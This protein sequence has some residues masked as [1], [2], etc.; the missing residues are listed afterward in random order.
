MCGKC[1]LEKT[2]E[3]QDVLVVAAG[4]G[5]GQYWIV[6]NAVSEGFGH[7][8]EGEKPARVTGS[9]AEKDG[10]NWIT[11]TAMEAPAY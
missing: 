2:A 7:T 8:C 9:V 10:Q 1:A 3:C 5:E 6:K 11:P 4:D